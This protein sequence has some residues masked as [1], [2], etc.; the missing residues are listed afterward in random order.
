M[1]ALQLF[2]KFQAYRRYSGQE[3]TKVN[4]DQFERV[5]HD[6]QDLLGDSCDH[7]RSSGCMHES[8]IRDKSYPRIVRGFV[9]TTAHTIRCCFFAG[10]KC[11]FQCTLNASYRRSPERVARAREIHAR[12]LFQMFIIARLNP[13]RTIRNLIATSLLFATAITNLFSWSTKYS[14]HR[15]AVAM[16]QP[17]P[18]GLDN[19]TDKTAEPELEPAPPRQSL[20][21]LIFGSLSTPE[22]EIEIPSQPTLED[23]TS[24]KDDDND[25]SPVEI[26]DKQPEEQ[27][28]PTDNNNKNKT[29]E[30]KEI[31]GLTSVDQDKYFLIAFTSHEK[32]QFVRATLANKM[33]PDLVIDFYTK[34]V[35]WKQS[36]AA[37]T[38]RD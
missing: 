16:F 13:W 12:S 37:E 4:V 18:G 34:Q 33:F 23:Q 30:V 15:L 31:L 2:N 5:T 22:I 21:N 35:K 29:Y 14:I 38:V 25:S 8:F 32:P 19:N 20:D 27:K 7:M 9:Y 24:S 26:S 1:I 3:R 28:Q 6:R 10:Q 36:R 11:K 17:W